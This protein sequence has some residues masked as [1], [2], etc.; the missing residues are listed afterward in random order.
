MSSPKVSIVLVNWNNLEDTVECIDS[1]V[2]CTYPA[3]D[4]TVV[5]NGSDGDDAMQLRERFGEAIRLI[6]S[7]TNVGFAGGSNLGIRDALDRGADYVLLLNNDTV[8]GPEFLDELVA[9]VGGDPGIGIAGGKILCYEFPQLIWSAGGN[10]DYRRGSTPVRGSGEVDDARFDREAEVDWIC[11]CFMLVSREVWESVGL[12]D[13]RFF[14]GW[15]DVDLCVRAAKGGHRVVY[16]P[17]SVVWHKAFGQTKKRRLQGR[18]LYYATRGH[19][20]FLRKHYN[21][22]QLLS[23]GLHMVTGFPRAMWDYSRITGQWN[24]PMYMVRA[25]LDSVRMPRARHTRR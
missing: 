3:H 17:R 12:L 16:A 18:P 8:A 7:T 9:S 6:E 2:R 5:D 15:E 21:R 24:G 20:L 10:I 1:L 23:A 22:A 11:S 14:F 19:F 4:V 13:E 25:L